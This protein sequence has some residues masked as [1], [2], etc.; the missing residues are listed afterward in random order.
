[1]AEQLPSG[2]TDDMNVAV[3]IGRTAEELADHVIRTAL[4]GWPDDVTERDLIATFGLSA[5]EPARARERTFGGI[6]RAATRN[7]TNC[8]SR[9]KDPIAWASFQLATREP[10]NIAAIDPKWASREA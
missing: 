6:V 1:V 2:R 3:P 10:S 8:P 9:E 4:A 5:E 7:E